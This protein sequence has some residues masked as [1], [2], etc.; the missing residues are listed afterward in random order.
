MTAL[1]VFGLGYSARRYVADYR[2]L[3][4]HIAGTMRDPARAQNLAPDVPGSH[5]DIL[6]FDGMSVTPSLRAKVREA[7]AV[8]VSIPP[9]GDHDPVLALLGETLLEAPRLRAVVYLSTVGIY[10]D[11][12]G[13]WV[14]EDTPPAPASARSRARVAAERAWQA[15]GERRNIPV[16]LLRLAGIYGPGSN[17]LVNLADG[18]AKRL[19]KPGQVFNRIHVADIAQ[20]IDAAFS[21]EASGAFNVCDNEPA[22]P[23]DVVSFAAELMGITPPPAV[24]FDSA[25]ASLSPMALTFYGE[26]KRVRN[27]RLTHELGVTLRYPTYREGLTALWETGEA[28]VNRAAGK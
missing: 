22:P 11:H 18:S 23:Q 7:D 20:A 15:F 27:A 17:A 24:S 16:A 3:W 5:V 4:R 9:V 6:S 25:R 12:D 26:N 8:L 13:A 10:G 14:D 2:R 28:R 21:H 19:I 1:I